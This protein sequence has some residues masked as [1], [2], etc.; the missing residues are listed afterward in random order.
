MSTKYSIEI[1][2]NG[3]ESDYGHRGDIGFYSSYGTIVAEGNS[4]DELLENATVDIQDQWGGELCVV[5]ADK[6][7]MHD[8]IVNKFM[9]LYGAESE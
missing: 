4:L 8:L 5:E 2:C 6:Q 7:W 9:R 1:D 3:A